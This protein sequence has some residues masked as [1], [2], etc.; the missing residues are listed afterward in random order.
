MEFEIE[1]DP[2]ARFLQRV[3]ETHAF[4]HEER[5]AHLR[6]TDGIAELFAQTHGRIERLD[7]ERDGDPLLRRKMCARR[8]GIHPLAPPFAPSMTT[9]PPCSVP[10]TLRIEAI[11]CRRQ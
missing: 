5:A 2:Y 11:P 7:I 3:H 4:A 10:M 6:Q 9:S 1:K 8:R